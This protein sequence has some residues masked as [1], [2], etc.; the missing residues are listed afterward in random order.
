M[1]HK[2]ITANEGFFFKRNYI[3]YPYGFSLS[4]GYNDEESNY[5]QIPLSEY[6]E[7]DIIE[8]DF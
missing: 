3:G 4:L 1:E 2:V 8:E 7:I 6:Q 5:D